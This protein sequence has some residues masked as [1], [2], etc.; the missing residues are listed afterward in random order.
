MVI[1]SG[2]IPAPDDQG[3]ITADGSQQETNNPD[4]VQ[5]PA[6]MSAQHGSA[7]GAGGDPFNDCDM[8][9]DCSDSLLTQWQLGDGPDVRVSHQPG[10]GHLRAEGTSITA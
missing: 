5:L 3:M 4:N 2:K 10:D 9:N 8:V 1:S 7:N 6:P